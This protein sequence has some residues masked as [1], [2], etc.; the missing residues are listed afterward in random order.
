[1]S[2]PTPSY[3]FNPISPSSL[4]LGFQDPMRKKGG[5]LGMLKYRYI[6]PGRVNILDS[7]N[8]LIRKGRLEK[9][10]FLPE[11]QHPQLSADA[12]SICEETH[13]CCTRPRARQC[14]GT[15]SLGLM[16]I[17]L[18]PSQIQM[19]MYFLLWLLRDG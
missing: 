8:N 12:Q 10:L 18:L 2:C 9:E 19:E 16:G 13:W 6:N 11:A 1:M 15:E 7:L 3:L 4:E 14:L 17:L 5:G